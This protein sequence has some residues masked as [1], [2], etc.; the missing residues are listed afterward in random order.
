MCA[1]YPHRQFMK[2]SNLKDKAVH[3]C[4][5]QIFPTLIHLFYNWL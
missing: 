1:E 4:K 3:Q 2:S 5:P